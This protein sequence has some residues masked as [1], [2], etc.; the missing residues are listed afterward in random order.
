VATIP[1][2]PHQSTPFIGRHRE[3]GEIA[4]RLPDPACRLLTLLGPDG[5]GKT[6]LALQAAAE[7]LPHFA[8]GVHFVALAPISSPDLIASALAGALQFSFFGS[9]DPA[10]QI[11]HY[12]SEKHM[13]LVMDNFEHLLEGTGL[14]TDILQAAN[15]I[16]ILATSR[17]RL[18]VQ[19]EWVFSVDGLSFPSEL[20]N[21]SLE[22]YGAVQLFVQRARQVQA[23]FSL[24]ENA[25]AVQAICQQVEGMPLGLELASSWLRV[26]SCR[27]IAAQMASSLDFLTTPLRNVPERHRSL[28][29]VFEQSWSLLSGDEQAALMKLSVFRGGFDREAAERVAGA[30][31]PLLAG[32]ADKSLLRMNATERYD[33]HELLRQ[34]AADK[35]L[36][37]G[38]MITAVQ[39]H[40]DYFLNLAERAEVNQFGRGQIAW[41]DRLE[42]EFDNLRA[43][44]VRS[45][46]TETGLHLAGALGWFFSERAHLSEGLDW[47]KQTLA[48][49][50]DAPASLRAK[51]L[52]SA[53]GLAGHLGDDGRAHALCEQALIVARATND[54]WNVAWSLNHLAIWYTTQADFDQAAALLDESLALFRVI[55]DPMG[56]THTLIR[57]AWS[58]IDQGDYPYARE[59]VEEALILAREA[60]DTITTAWVFYVLGIVS[61]RYDHDF[62][63]AAIQYERSLSLFREARFILGVPHTLIALAGIEQATGNHA[64]AQKLYVEGMIWL[65]ERRLN[66]Y[67]LDVG[68]VGL[69]SIARVRGQWIRVARLLGAADAIRLVKHAGLFPTLYT[70]DTDVTSVRTQ[71]GEAAFAEAWAVGKAM[72]REQ[73]VTY[74]L[75][76]EELEMTYPLQA[77]NQPLTNPLTK[78]EIEILHLMAEGLSNR[79]IAEGLIIAVGTVK[80]YG[81]QICSKLQARNRVQAI[82]RARELNILL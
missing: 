20:S 15:G 25:Q 36:D 19:E 2:L 16:K 60:D 21:T 46:E 6:R 45:M 70:L 79:E 43:A 54:R 39:Q 55:N 29:A 22:G 80:W 67:L 24:D 5:I 44:L 56:I 11:I 74:A 50:E 42:V 66:H 57:R 31:L 81:S 58:A 1:N 35:L 10:I 59:L 23:H 51:A 37:A 62:R 77:T 26:M 7:Q 34:Y 71:L 82:A 76:S 4:V 72:T 52:H 33:L 18:N 40:L 41:F 3:L 14:L 8:D 69:A 38:M 27:Q 30:S 32:L 47:L 49:N 28:R 9:E 68:I 73:A 12:L 61:W 75:Q 78:R 17:E 63:Q 48:A 64:R 13:L 65:W 53:G